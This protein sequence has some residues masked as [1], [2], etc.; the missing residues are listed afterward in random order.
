MN[1]RLLNASVLAAGAALALTACGSDSS[2]GGSASGDGVTTI[3]LVAADYGSNGQNP[4]QAYWDG[5]IGA[6]EQANPKIKVDVQV[7]NWND[8]STKLSTMVQN[9]QYP[10]V[11]EGPGYASFAQSGLLYTADQ[12]L[13]PAVQANLIPSLAKAGDQGGAA[14]GIPF[15]SSSRAFLI[16]NALWQKAKLPMNGNQAVAPKTWADVESDAKALKAAGVE[17]PLG[18]PLGSEEA[19]AESF[20]WEMNNGGGYVDASGKWAI[21]SPANI[22]TFKQLGTWVN[23]G[24]TEKD[25][26]S[27]KRTDLYADFASGKVGMLNGMP[28]Q[29]QDVQKSNLDVTWAPLP[30]A[31]TGQTPQT[32]GVGDWIY[33]FKAGGHASQVKAFLDFAFQKQWQVKFDEEYDLLPVTQDAVTQVSK[34]VPALVPFLKALPAARFVPVSNPAWDTVNAQVKVQ[35]GGALKD[36]QG[37]LTTLQ[38]AATQAGQ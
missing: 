2:G 37:V 29:L 1:R 25:P 24:L 27:V 19:Q 38:T 15:V 14:Y 9:K 5:V 21:N 10:D 22:A 23:E 4:S 31:Q 16:N 34:D 11:V 26:G 18:L 8:I 33:G 20:M 3:K 13:D 36:P 28:I 7:I 12:V 30:T 6:F 17:V 35:I 32:L